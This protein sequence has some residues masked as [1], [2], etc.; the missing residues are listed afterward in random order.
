MQL[1]IIRKLY[2]LGKLDKVLS[3][4][5]LPWILWILTCFAMIFIWKESTN[6]ETNIGPTIKGSNSQKIDSI[7]N[8]NNNNHENNGNDDDDDSYDEPNVAT[9]QDVTTI[10]Q[11]LHQQQQQHDT[12]TNNNVEESDITTTTN[13]KFTTTTTTSTPISSPHEYMETPSQHKIR[14]YFE[15]GSWFTKGRKYFVFQTS[16][17]LSN[18]RIILETALIIGETLNRTV[19]INQAAWHSS[20]WYNYNKIKPYEMIPANELFD[21]TLMGRMAPAGLV[22]LNVVSLKRF[23]EKNENQHGQIWHRIERDDLEERR[24]DPWSVRD[25]RKKFSRDKSDVLFFAKGT[26]WEGFNFE[27]EEIERAQRS[28]RAHGKYR[29]AA[30][31]AVLTLFPNGFNSLHIRFMDPDGLHLREGFLSSNRDFVRRMR[32]YD[33]TIPLYIATVPKRRGSAYFN[34]FINPGG[35]SLV[36]GDKLEALDEIKQFISPQTIPPAM[37]ETVLGLIEQLVCARGKK[38]LGTGFSTFSEHIRRM[39]RWRELVVA[40]D[41]D[42]RNDPKENEFVNMVTACNIPTRPC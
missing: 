7:T 42:A 35:F 11:Q 31:R 36:Y 41:E 13:K 5:R 10:E 40:D 12:N 1:P 3:S 39:R 25:L 4:K 8:N 24:D 19:V 37:V 28:V 22:F 6:I 14:E 15:S 9:P 21:E 20:M 16:G 26:M 38:F 18:Q 23:V 27:P 34:G 2:S 33:K 17:G 30:R 29:S 32:F